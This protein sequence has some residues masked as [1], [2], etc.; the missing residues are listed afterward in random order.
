MMSGPPTIYP[1][2][3]RLISNFQGDLVREWLCNCFTT[4]HNYDIILASTPQNPYLPSLNRLAEILAQYGIESSVLPDGPRE[5]RIKSADQNLIFRRMVIRHPVLYVI[6]AIRSNAPTIFQPP[7]VPDIQLQLPPP[8]LP[9]RPFQ[10]TE[11]VQ[12]PVNLPSPLMEQPRNVPY[13]PSGSSPV[14]KK[15]STS[16][17]M[18]E[19]AGTTD[20]EIPVYLPP[21]QDVLAMGPLQ[22]R[23]R[24]H[25][26]RP[27][28]AFRYSRDPSTNSNRDAPSIL[29]SP[30]IIS[31]TA[32]PPSLS[33]TSTDTPVPIQQNQND[34][35]SNSSS[36]RGSRRPNMGY[37][38]TEG[39]FRLY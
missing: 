8:M 10:A 9:L 33:R 5:F 25:G 34:N 16:P 36:T 38:D 15:S 31:T 29:T 12:G 24:L 39:R 3:N 2:D 26:R 17:T 1:A 7:V 13:F 20:G 21:E 28:P 32:N 35:N 30:S 4:P 27:R 11:T 37:W 14:V 18:S 19:A 6:L 22:S 23:E